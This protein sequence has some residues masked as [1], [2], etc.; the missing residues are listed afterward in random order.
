VHVKKGDKLDDSTPVCQIRIKQEGFLLPIECV[1]EFTLL[2]HVELS[3]KTEP[4]GP[5]IFGSYIP[6]SSLCVFPPHKPFLKSTCR[7]TVT[8]S[9][10]HVNRPGF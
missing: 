3:V 9:E 4:E 8:R 7:G 1:Q 6:P 10:Q 5:L 2:V